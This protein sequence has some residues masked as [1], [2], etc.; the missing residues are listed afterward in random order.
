MGDEVTTEGYGFLTEK[1]TSAGILVTIHFGHAMDFSCDPVVPSISQP[2]SQTDN[3]M[4][5]GIQLPS[6]CKE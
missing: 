4:S 6:S 3:R 5:A 1:G 2:E